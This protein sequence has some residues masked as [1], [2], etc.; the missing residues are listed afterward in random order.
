[1]AT[2]GAAWL[3]FSQPPAPG[4]GYGEEPSAAATFEPQ[5]DSRTITVH[6]VC[7]TDER[8]PSDQSCSS[9][10]ALIRARKRGAS[11]RD[12]LQLQRKILRRQQQQHQLFRYQQQKQR[13]QPPGRIVATAARDPSSDQAQARL[14]TLLEVGRYAAAKCSFLL[15][16]ACTLM[17]ALVCGDDE[18]WLVENIPCTALT[19][20]PRSPAGGLSP[21]LPLAPFQARRGQRYGRAAPARGGGGAPLCVAGGPAR[22]K[23]ERLELRFTIFIDCL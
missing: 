7:F 16:V 9:V 4:G 5:E 21:S 17:M 2:G 3:W 23:G 6:R 20:K 8:E 19:R 10:A 12:V 22:R 15:V 11:I 18:G 14:V 13:R 1:M